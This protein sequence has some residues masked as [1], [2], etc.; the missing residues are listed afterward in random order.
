MKCFWSTMILEL[1]LLAVVLMH[2]WAYKILMM[3]VPTK[4]H[5]FAVAAM[6]ESLVNK[7]HRVV[8]FVG[9]NFPLNLPELRNRSEFSVIRY[10]NAKNETYVS[11]DT[12]TEQVSKSAIESGGDGM[13]MTP[14]MW[15]MC[16]NLCLLLHHLSQTECKVCFFIRLCLGYSAV[17]YV[18]MKAIDHCVQ[19][20]KH[21]L[22]FSCIS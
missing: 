5:V 15:N 21:P 6:S 20:K 13:Q 8:L 11:Y 17:G 7:G 19:I 10:R 1:L 18:E 2:A 14:L 4:S 3:P 22:T 9:E 12:V 16:V